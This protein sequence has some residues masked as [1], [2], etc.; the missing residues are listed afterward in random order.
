[1]R[2]AIGSLMQETNTLVPF[3]TTVETFES[4]YL[5]RGTGMLTGYG[6]AR[7]EVP[8][9]L[10][11]FAA[12]GAE[13]VPLVGGYAGA[14][15]IVTR[16]AFDELVSEMTDRLAA[17]GRVDGVALALHGAMVVEDEPDAESEIVRRV[18][19]VVG[20]GVPIGVS[21][22][23]HGHITAAMLQPDVFYVGYREYPHIDMWET[24]TRVAELLLDTIAGRRRPVMALAKRH[25]IVTPMVATTGREP[26]AT[27]VRAARAHE[28]AGDCLHASL[29]PVQ[30]WLDVP[31]LG[32]AALVC[33]D[34]DLASAQRVADDLAD[35][36]WE[37]R[38]GFEPELV[39]LDDAIRIGLSGEGTTVVSDIGDSP[40][41]GAAADSTAVLAALL[42]LGAD[43]AGRLVYLTLC[44][45]IA[46]KT[47]AQVG[48][49]KRVRLRLGHRNSP[50][51]GQPIEVDARVRAISDG[52]FTMYDAGAEGTVMQLGLTAVLAIGDVRI[53]VRSN[54]AFEWD[55]GLFAAF[56]LELKRAALV[57]VKSPAHF[58][59]A[60][61]PHAA[62]I[63]VADT[64]GP[65]CGNMRRL[66]LERV[67]R[68]LYPIDWN[69]QA[70]SSSSS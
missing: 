9:F 53:V 46:A 3:R 40:S 70:P 59:V 18:R 55:T 69:D 30:P 27:I 8:A 51:D 19:A 66:K 49:G 16:A 33:A 11:V 36:A 24:A 47:A 65:T 15:G 32:F 1:M 52:E 35:M 58:R 31:D 37:A 20:P 44:D 60:F 7:V 13:V 61:G 54:P 26:L 5:H 68:P 2:I 23:L 38:E 63:L 21:L 41:G 17:A 42:R 6:A 62:R 14:S 67:T 50:A 45:A 25:M 57:F 43:K 12:A 4:F 29:F 34:G 39:A 22:D 64:P 48:P 28:A 56:G 10:S